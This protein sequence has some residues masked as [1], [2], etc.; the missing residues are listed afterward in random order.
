[1]SETTPRVSTGTAPQPDAA[2]LLREAV[3]LA[4]QVRGEFE[5]GDSEFGSD[6][7]VPDNVKRLCHLLEW[8][9][10]H[11]LSGL[12]SAAFVNLVMGVQ[13]PDA[14]RERE[15]KCRNCGR[16]AA[17]FGAY[18]G[19]AAGFACNDCCGHGDEDGGCV[20]LDGDP[21]GA[22]ADL[23]RECADAIRQ[24]RSGNAGACWVPTDPRLLADMLDA[25]S[26]VG[27]PTET[28]EPPPEAIYGTSASHGIEIVLR[29]VYHRGDDRLPI[30]WAPYVRRLRAVLNGSPT[31]GQAATE[32]NAEGGAGEVDVLGDVRWAPGSC[33]RCGYLPVQCACP[34]GPATSGSG[35]APASQAAPAP[36]VER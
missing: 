26:S 12:D 23:L 16:T 28:T 5:V 36:E 10:P 19:H 33:Q 8:D 6:P 25:L 11:A 9:L 15:P 31:E 32:P 27:S 29:E 22:A 14:S 3:T 24:G 17:C 1:M 4:F 34:P 30:W 35:D 21:M 13:V 18:E 7:G 2:A 20:L